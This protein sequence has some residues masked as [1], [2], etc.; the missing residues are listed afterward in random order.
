VPYC[1]ICSKNQEIFQQVN[2][3]SDIIF[4]VINEVLSPLRARSHH[5]NRNRLELPRLALA[6]RFLE[7]DA[8]TFAQFF[9]VLGNAGNMTGNSG[10]TAAGVGS[11]DPAP[12][13]L[14]RLTLSISSAS[15]KVVSI[16]ATGCPQP[17][18][19]SASAARSRAMS[20]RLVSRMRTRVLT[21]F[22][23]CSRA[24]LRT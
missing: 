8:L 16:C 2:A 15:D 23:V 20:L 21:A 3:T 22:S 4:P 5:L 7:A 13:T 17:R 1:A 12:A 14:R 19:S 18:A 11:T 9:N 6:R 24:K 10:T